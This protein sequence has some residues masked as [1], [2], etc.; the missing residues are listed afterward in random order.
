MA[1]SPDGKTLATWCWDNLFLWDVQ[2]GERRKTLTGEPRN[3]VNSMAFS[4]DSKTFASAMN[5][6]TIRLWNIQTGEL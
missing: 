6:G 5:N 1:F 3:V 2:T 4:P